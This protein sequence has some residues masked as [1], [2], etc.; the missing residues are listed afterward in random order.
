M[1][2]LRT[3]A[4]IGGVTEPRILK[5]IGLTDFV[6]GQWPI[7]RSLLDIRGVGSGRDRASLLSLP[8]AGVLAGE[9]PQL[10]ADY[11]GVVACALDN[12]EVVQ[13]GDVV[14]FSPGARYVQNL[15]RRRAHTNALFI[16]ERCNNWCLMCSQPPRNVDDTWRIPEL[17]QTVDLID[18]TLG[19]LGITGGEPTLIG[20]RLK[21]LLVHCRQQLP[22]TGVHVLTNGRRFSDRTFAARFSGAHDRLVWAV[23]LY[24]D[25]AA[26]HDYVVQAHGA[27]ADTVR[28]LYGL[29]QAGQTI[30]IRVVLQRPTAER[31]TQLGDFIFRSFPFVSHVAFMGLEP[32][33][34]ALANRNALWIDPADYIE[35][36]SDVVMQL[37]DVGMSVSIYNLPLCVLPTSLWSFSRRS[38]SEWK[39]QH[40]PVCEPCVIRERCGGF[41]AS[42]TAEWQSRHVHAL[43]A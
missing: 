20:E 7:E 34:F 25:T 14:R 4:T 30:E 18:Q 29:H 41:F 39:Q 16:T 43:L 33:G 36:L 21:E 26:G 19:W 22:A 27:F 37:H 3:A 2:T 11:A 38:I 1:L 12:D 32:T 5:V 24:G 8:W 13:P 35:V 10:P 6:S 15:Y 9:K 31:L 23:P 17:F 28:G 42:H 40:L